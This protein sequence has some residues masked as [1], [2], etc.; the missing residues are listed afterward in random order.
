MSRVLSRG[1]TSFLVLGLMLDD[2]SVFCLFLCSSSLNVS[3]HTDIKVCFRFIWGFLGD[4]KK[5][6]RGPPLQH[7]R[8]EEPQLL[9]GL[10]WAALQ[11]FFRF[12]FFFVSLHWGKTLS[13]APWIP[14]SLWLEPACME[15]HCGWL[16]HT[17]E[18]WSSGKPL[19]AYWQAAGVWHN[20]LESI[21]WCIYSGILVGC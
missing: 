14:C 21:V 15:S 10:L 2:S 7:L 1:N 18:A 20:S 8:G 13:C 3:E 17:Q 4:T 11:V 9:P 16:C 5:A 6:S 12:V 19:T